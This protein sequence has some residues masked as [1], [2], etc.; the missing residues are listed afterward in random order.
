MK[1]FQ[2][3]SDQRFHQRLMGYVKL[4]TDEFFNENHADFR[5]YVT[6]FSYQ[7]DLLSQ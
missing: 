4:F 5:Y 7:N 2:I 1:M 6:Y 3:Y